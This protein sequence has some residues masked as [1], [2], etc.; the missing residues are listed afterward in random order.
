MFE[1]KPFW[2]EVAHIGTSPPP[3]C[4]IVPFIGH[5]PAVP[6]VS[7]SLKTIAGLP[8]SR[9]RLFFSLDTC[10]CVGERNLGHKVG[11]KRCLSQLERRAESFASLR[12]EA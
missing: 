8:L 7:V 1:E 12:H 11:S 10:A 6:H 2:A 5:S 3:H 4:A 9:C